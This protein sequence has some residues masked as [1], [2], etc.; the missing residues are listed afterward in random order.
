MKLRVEI[1]VPYPKKK[2][3]R[4]ERKKVEI[5][6]KEETSATEYMNHFLENA[7]QHTK[8]ACLP[9]RN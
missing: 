1:V 7:C 5:V 4:K 6:V 8:H 2:K 3:K 9:Y